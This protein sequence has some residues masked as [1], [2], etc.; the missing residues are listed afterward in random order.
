MKDACM[1]LKLV[2]L[3]TITRLRKDGP[4]I[5]FYGGRMPT[6]SYLYRT[7]NGV[8]AHERNGKRGETV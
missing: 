5:V 7:G 3:S 8:I 2:N 1:P 4:T 6:S